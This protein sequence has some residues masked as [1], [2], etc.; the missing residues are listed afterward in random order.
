MEIEEQEHEPLS[1]LS[2]SFRSHS[3]NWSILEKEA[4]AVVESMIRLEYLTSVK[5]VDVFTDHSN[6]LYIFDTH[7]RDPGISKQAA[8]KLM[9]WEFKLS[10]YR[11]VIEYVEGTRN[12]GAD[13][14]ARWAVKQREIT[15]VARLASVIYAPI[16]TVEKQEF[17]WPSRTFIKSRNPSKDKYPKKLVQYE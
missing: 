7:G 8:N 11:C 17:D 3:K 14:P 10:A 5:E 9:R 6:L 16:S 15:Q 13:M 12:V 2:G 4:F 1:F